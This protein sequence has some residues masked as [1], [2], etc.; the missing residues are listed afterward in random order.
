MYTKRN[1]TS[2]RQDGAKPYT[3]DSELIQ[4]RNVAKYLADSILTDITK[5][6]YTAE[7]NYTG[8][9]SLTLNNFIWYKDGLATPNYYLIKRHNLYWAGY[10]TG[11]ATLST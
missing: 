6:Y 8:D 3:I 1:A 11:S 5:E 9:I 7:I 4:D 2:I 10:L